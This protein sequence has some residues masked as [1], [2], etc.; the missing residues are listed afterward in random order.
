MWIPSCVCATTH[1][2][3]SEFGLMEY[4]YFHMLSMLPALNPP[5]Q[6]DQKPTLNSWQS[7]QSFG[8]V[9]LHNIIPGHAYSTESTLVPG[10]AESL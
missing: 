9:A 5:F 10:K 2:K 4:G 6:L 3:T 8:L 7:Y 1:S